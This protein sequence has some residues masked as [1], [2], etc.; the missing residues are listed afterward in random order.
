MRNYLRLK[1]SKIAIYLFLILNQFI[2]SAD[3]LSFSKVELINQKK[4]IPEKKNNDELDISSAK[5]TNTYEK[6]PIEEVKE[7]EK[8]VEETL[9]K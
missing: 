8:F 3:A 9:V 4:N 1:N 7:L 2:F 5:E 6:A